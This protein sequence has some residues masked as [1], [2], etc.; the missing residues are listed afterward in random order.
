[1]KK[2]DRTG[3]TKKMNNGLIATITTYKNSHCFTVLFE[4]GWLVPEVKHID[5]FEQGTV[6]YHLNGTKL[7]G[8]NLDL[9]LKIKDEAINIWNKNNPDEAYNF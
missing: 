4:N 2:I 3:W 7:K 6:D 1:M 5:Q 9:A 8:M